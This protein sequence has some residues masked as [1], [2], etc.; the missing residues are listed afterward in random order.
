MKAMLLFD[1]HPN[2]PCKKCPAC[3]M[4]SEYGDCVCQI[5][6]QDIPGDPDKGPRPKYCPIIF[7]A[8]DKSVGEVQ[9]VTKTNYDGVRAKLYVCDRKSVYIATMNVT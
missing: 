6:E 4:V 2:D 3:T 9:F 7:L 1:L 5:T 8:V